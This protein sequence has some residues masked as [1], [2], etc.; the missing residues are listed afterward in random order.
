M[1]IKL[2]ESFENIPYFTI[3]GFKQ[4]LA[5]EES[6]TQTIREMLSRWV[7]NRHLIRIKRGV[8]MTRRFY[9]LHRDHV[10]FIPA[11]SSII[12]P[13]SYISLEY[14]LQ[15]NRVLTEITYSV[16]AVTMK[17]TRSIENAIGTFD[18]RHIKK[19]LYTGFT[20]ETFYGIQIHQASL[21]KALFDYFYLRPL[22]ENWRKQQIN[23]AEEFRLNLDDF[24]SKIQAEFSE[25]VVSSSSSKM[26]YIFDNLRHTVWQQ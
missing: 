1:K 10:N 11:V 20:Q 15:R 16:T 7:L 25:F 2:L 17:N 21:A 12:L 8:Y 23:L 18:Y 5:A 19:S 13:Q 6:D 22:P 26:N 14:V 3:N 9:E 24:S 4:A